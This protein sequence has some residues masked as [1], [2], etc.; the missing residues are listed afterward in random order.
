MERKVSE[1]KVD[2][3][4]IKFYYCN[5]YNNLN[6]CWRWLKNESEHIFSRRER[7]RVANFGFQ[8]ILA[9]F[10]VDKGHVNGPE[11]HFISDKGIIYIFNARTHLYITLLIARP[12]QILR[13]YKACQIEVNKNVDKVLKLARQ[14]QLDMLNEI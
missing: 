9:A 6:N 1:K 14:H 5:P 12:N 8:T 2:H 3:C 7:Q 10:F 13:Y 11:I 4:F